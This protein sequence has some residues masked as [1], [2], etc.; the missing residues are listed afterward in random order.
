M[1]R[2]IEVSESQAQAIKEQPRTGARKPLPAFVRKL[3][4]L[5]RMKKVEP[6]NEDG[7]TKN[8]MRR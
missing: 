2:P 3:I 6:D 7:K 5:Q 1:G 4:N 8:Q